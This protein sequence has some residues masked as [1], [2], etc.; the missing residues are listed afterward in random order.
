M[1][2]ALPPIVIA[3]TVSTAEPAPC[4][5]M[6][7]SGRSSTVAWQPPPARPGTSLLPNGKSGSGGGVTFKKV[8]WL[9]PSI[10]VSLS[11]KI[12]SGVNGVSSISHQH[13]VVA[14]MV[15]GSQGVP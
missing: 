14:E 1:F 8:V 13:G 15:A 12:G 2:E 10:V 9:P 4:A 5:L 6:A 11:V 3:P 7:I